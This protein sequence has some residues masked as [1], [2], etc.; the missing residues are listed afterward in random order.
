MVTKSE[1]CCSVCWSV[2]SCKVSSDFFFVILKISLSL[3]L[4]AML[5][6]SVDVI[7]T[8]FAYYK[9]I[10]ITQERK[11]I[12]KKRFTPSFIIF[13]DLSSKTMFV[14]GVWCTLKAV[15]RFP[16]NDVIAD[17]ASE[18]GSSSEINSFLLTTM[19]SDINHIA[20]LRSTWDHEDCFTASLG[21]LSSDNG[22]RL[23]LKKQSLLQWIIIHVIFLN[24]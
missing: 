3:R 10:Q 8:L 6:A 22:L 1:W 23:P 12:S 11:S 2:S 14:L 18:Q 15:S 4:A 9:K 5:L 7:T 17:T 16:A 13:N 24:H 21:N 19:H 20:L